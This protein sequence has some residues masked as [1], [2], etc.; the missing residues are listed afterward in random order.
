MGKCPQFRTKGI[1]PLRVMPSYL[2]EEPYDEE[3]PD[4]TG[5]S[6]NAIQP[7]RRF[8]WWGW[9]TTIGGYISGNG[10]IWPF[11]DPNWQKHL[12]T[13]GT[14]DMERLNKF[15]KSIAWWKLVPSGLGGM[16]T[17]ITEGASIP[18]N[19]DYVAAAATPEGTLL[20]A[21]IPPAHKGSITVNT[22][23]LER[24]YKCKMV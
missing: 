15:I 5:V 19:P 1:F 14:H 24:K 7:V 12:D 6:P 11:G 23:V 4:G 17:I 20:L 3:G 21:Y 8:Q 10:Y 2:L 16:P 9:L 18:D 22:S 13:Q